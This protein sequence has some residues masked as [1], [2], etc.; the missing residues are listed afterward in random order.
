MELVVSM[1]L[2]IILPKG[3]KA[4]LLF[5]CRRLAFAQQVSTE[6]ASKA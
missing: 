6:R 2:E 3:E 4:V 5:P 1:V